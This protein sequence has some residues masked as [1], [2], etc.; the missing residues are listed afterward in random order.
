VI[1]IGESLRKNEPLS[2][3]TDIKKVKKTEQKLEQD[4][5]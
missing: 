2:S 1:F 3:T 5:K 4:A